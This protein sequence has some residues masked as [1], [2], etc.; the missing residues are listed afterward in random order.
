MV[1]Q[2]FFTMM[3]ILPLLQLT[4]SHPGPHMQVSGELQAPWTQPS[5][6]IAEIIDN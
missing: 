6:Q 2:A 3:N 5:L 1:I 4:P